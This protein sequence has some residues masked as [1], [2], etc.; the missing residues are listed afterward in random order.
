MH[1]YTHF[2]YKCTE[3]NI[4]DYN[5][6]YR[7]IKQTI[8]EERKLKLVMKSELDLIIT[9]LITQLSFFCF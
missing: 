3:I 8:R 9:Y 7:I 5:R 2:L 1:T 6:G 4:K